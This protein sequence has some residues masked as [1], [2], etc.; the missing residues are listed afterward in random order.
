[1]LY[2]KAMDDYTKAIAL[3]PENARHYYSRGNT[4]VL[5][6]DDPNAILSDYS[7]AIKLDSANPGYYAARANIYAVTLQYD[8]ALADYNKT[9]SLKADSAEYFGSRASLQT[10]AGDYDNAFKDYTQAISLNPTNAQY[11]ASRGLLYKFIQIDTNKV[12]DDFNKAIALRPGEALFYSYRGTCYRSVNNWLK[13]KDD[14]SKSCEQGIKPD[15]AS[16][17]EINR[18]IARGDKWVF[19]AVT[20]HSNYYYDHTNLFYKNKDVVTVW[21]RTEQ[22]HIQDNKITPAPPWYTLVYSVY[23]CTAKE[24]AD[25]QIVKYNENGSVLSSYRRPSIDYERVV[26]GSVG[27]ILMHILCKEDKAPVKIKKKS[28]KSK[29]REK[30]T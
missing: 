19:F 10:K 16:L 21:T 11:Y 13:A 9:I 2:K 24:D 12:I 20:S 18:D 26:P 8:Q 17:S 3:E 29:S 27:E 7:T 23:N 1:M 4:H 6:G 30:E 25:I 14:F 28:K 22:K 5:L 15:C